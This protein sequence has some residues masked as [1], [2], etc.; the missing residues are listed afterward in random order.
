MQHT[1]LHPAFASSSLPPFLQAAAA[2]R[3]A[4]KDIA[5]NVHLQHEGYGLVSDLLIADAAF[6]HKRDSWCVARS[7]F[8]SPY[9]VANIRYIPVSF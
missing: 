9:A 4:G 1:A 3:I 7:F 2:A 8:C 6:V 5:G